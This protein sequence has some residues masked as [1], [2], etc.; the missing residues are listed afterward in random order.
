LELAS[1]IRCMKYE[2]QVPT[3][4]C[5]YR[6]KSKA[7]SKCNKCRQ[8]KELLRLWN[9]KHRKPIIKGGK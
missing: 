7:H 3:E 5:V 4:A 8:G 1:Y 9:E 6:Q 2:E